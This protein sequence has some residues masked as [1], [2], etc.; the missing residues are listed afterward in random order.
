[1]N[2]SLL[3]FIRRE[4]GASTFV[5]AVAVGIIVVPIA[6]A[7][8]NH[9]L[10]QTPTNPPLASSPRTSTPSSSPTISPTH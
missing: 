8:G 1:L 10:A 9:G 4:W 5:L 2:D 7:F 3:S 6:L